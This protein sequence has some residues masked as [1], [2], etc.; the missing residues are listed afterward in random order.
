MET[1]VDSTVKVVENT[2]KNMF[3]AMSLHIVE[4]VLT[5]DFYMAF[6]TLRKIT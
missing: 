3:A 6:L 5:I 2:G 1:S 4:A